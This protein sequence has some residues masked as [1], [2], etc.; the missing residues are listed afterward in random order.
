MPDPIKMRISDV[1]DVAPDIREF[2]L[3]PLDDVLLESSEPGAHVAVET[4]SGAWRQYSLVTPS[5]EPDFYRIAVKKEIGGRGGSN[6]IHENWAQGDK[7]LIKEPE[8]AFPLSDASEY[9]L[10]AGGIGVTPIHS[11]AQHLVAAGKV[12]RFIY[13]TRDRANTAYAEELEALL[14]DRLTLHHDQG[15]VDQLYDFWDH[16]AEPLNMHVYCCG[17]AALMEEI[18][19]VSGHW[20]EGSVNFEDFGGVDA[21]RDDDMAFEVTLKSSGQTLEVP[22]DRSIL[23]ALRESGTQV[24]SSCE[25]GTCGTCKVGLLSG[26]VDH[27]DM[28]LMDE[29]KAHQIMICVSRAKC[30]GLVLDL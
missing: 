11:M 12:V 19:S 2:T 21:V 5:D 27:R 30:G 14:G 9:L 24:S 16:F 17:P 20:P 3:E 6:S 22:A 10:I 13:C 25:S 18:K 28:V 26:D 29:E 4:P 7:I 1:R 23:E 8:N 15:D